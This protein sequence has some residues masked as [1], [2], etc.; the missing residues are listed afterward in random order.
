LIQDFEEAAPAGADIDM[1]AMIDLA[2]SLSPEVVARL[3]AAND[4]FEVS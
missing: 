1:N 3:L 4:A 2:K